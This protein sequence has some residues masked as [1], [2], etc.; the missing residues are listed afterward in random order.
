LSERFIDGT[1]QIKL[2]ISTEESVMPCPCGSRKQYLDCCGRY[3]ERQEIPETPEQLMRSRYVAYTRAN[4][5]YIIKTM[6]GEALHTFDVASAKQWAKRSIW[7]GLTVV[8]A[9]KPCDAIGYVEFIARFHYQGK[10][11]SIHERSEFHFEK[12]HW[13]YVT[14]NSCCS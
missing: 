9:P 6:T 10:T 7:L 12:G 11:Q 13:F 2:I 14:G 4:I 1:L 8:D 3:I 5:D